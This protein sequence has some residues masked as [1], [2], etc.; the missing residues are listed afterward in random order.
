MFIDFRGREEGRDRG[1]GEG[2]GQRDG[3][4]CEKHQLVAPSTPPHHNQGSKLQ[5]RYVP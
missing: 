3:H 2:E 5:P 4:G 1:A